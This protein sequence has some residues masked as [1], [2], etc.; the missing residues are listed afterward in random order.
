MSVFDINGNRRYGFFAYDP[1]FAGGVFVACGDV[2][3]DGRPEIVTGPG[4]GSGP[5]VDVFSASGQR[6]P[7]STP[8]TPPSRVACGSRSSIPTGPVARP[9][10]W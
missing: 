4:A 10:A 3:G 5:E 1:G 8:T 2:D 9:A 6:R 7:R